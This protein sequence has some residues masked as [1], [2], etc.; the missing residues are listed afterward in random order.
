MKPLFFSFCTLFFIFSCHQ[1]SN[2]K[3]EEDTY[4]ILSLLIDEFA[5]PVISPREIYNLEPFT[6]VQIDSIL[7]QNEKISIFPIQKKLIK[8][9]LKKRGLA[10]SLMNY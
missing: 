2:D 10:K 6:K 4:R 7:N 9:F 3:K 1:A 8:N 5:K